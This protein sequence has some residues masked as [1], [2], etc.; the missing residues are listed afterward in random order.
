MKD[1]NFFESYLDKR[2]FS[3]NKEFIYYT[4]SILLILSILIYSIYN[5]I[6]IRIISK[7]I[8]RL[9]VTV[10]DERTNKKVDQVSNKKEELDELKDFVEK[11][12]LLDNTLEEESV[13]DNRLLEAI[14]Y[15][16]PNEIFLTSISIYTEYIEIIGVAE[17]KWS[18]ADL[19]GNLGRIEEFKE[20]FISNIS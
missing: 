16:L 14:Q 13:I 5:Q 3:I 18:I 4:L 19:V 10:E 11:I 17:D 20:V 2:E 12:K 6:K 1:L 9:R 7:D 8:Y 15:S